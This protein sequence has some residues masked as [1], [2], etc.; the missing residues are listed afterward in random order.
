M[1]LSDVS[2]GPDW[3]I[4]ILIIVLFAISVTHSEIAREAG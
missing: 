2:S 1:K 4:W 3:L